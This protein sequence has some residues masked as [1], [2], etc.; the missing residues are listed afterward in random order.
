MLTLKYTNLFS[1][2]IYVSVLRRRTSSRV[3]STVLSVLSVL[4]FHTVPEGNKFPA[5]PSSNPGS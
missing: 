5:E 4:E 3:G 1:R 2:V